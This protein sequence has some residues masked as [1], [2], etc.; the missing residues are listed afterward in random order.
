MTWVRLA[1]GL[2]QLVNFVM[3]K[4]DQSQWEASGFKKAAILHLKA[5]NESVGM[6]EDAFKEATKA[7]PEERR[8][9]LKEPI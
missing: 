4:I 2:L 6:A 9:S 7:T 3:R 8:R 5:S 1:L